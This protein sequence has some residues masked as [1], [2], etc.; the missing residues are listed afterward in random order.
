MA[1]ERRQLPQVASGH[2]KKQTLLDKAAKSFISE[3]INTVADVAWNE[4]VKPF[5]KRSFVNA[6][7]ML[8][9]GNQSQRGGYYGSGSH[10]PYYRYSDSGVSYRENRRVAP[11][12]NRFDYMDYEFD[13]LEDVMRIIEELTDI[14]RQY[15]NV[16][17]TDVDTAIGITG[18]FTDQN[19]GWTDPRDFSWSRYGSKYVLNF[20]PPVPLDR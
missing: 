10:T 8:L 16:R 5:L 13:T 3:D 18:K 17:V 7:D 1:E 2:L 9:N 11:S 4:W 12:R 6:I 19:W 14:L 20:A 15:P